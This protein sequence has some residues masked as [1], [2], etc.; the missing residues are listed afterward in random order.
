M[1]EFFQSYGL[2]ILAVIS[3]LVNLILLILKKNKIV[4]KDTIFEKLL[5]KLPIFIQYAESM[6]KDGADKKGLALGAAYSF[7][8]QYSGLSHDEVVKMYSDR[9]S[10]AIESILATPQKKGVTEVCQ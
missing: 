6:A 9:I 7:I 4:V 2:V 1:K 10:N 5:E 8:S 3:S